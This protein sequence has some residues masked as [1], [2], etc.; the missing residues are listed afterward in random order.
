MQ[1]HNRRAIALLGICLLALGLFALS[2]EAV[3]ALARTGST[4]TQVRR[5][6]QR[7]IALGYLSGSADGIFGEKTRSALVQ[8]QRDKGIS[9]DGVAGVVTLTALG[10]VFQ[11]GDSGEDVTA[12]QQKLTALGYYSGSTDGIFGSATAAAVRSFQANNSLT[13]DGIVGFATAQ[14]L[15][16]GT[17]AAKSASQSY[18]DNDYELLARIINAEA[19]GEPYQGQVAVGAVVLNRVRHPS[20]PDTI[21]GVVYQ[22]GAFTAVTDGQIHAD[23]TD[24]AYR[25]AQDALAGWDPS[26]GAIY[27]YNPDKTSNR[28]IRSRTVI[29]TIG[30]HVFCE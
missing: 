10:I 23:I 14:A 16:S 30:A 3:P 4:G 21:A 26:G 12:I 22:S 5:V 20:F 7:L 27:Y 17:A 28:W 11:R 29:A 24:S 2:P 25:A 15:Y 1:H 19:R 18:R 8:F 6:Q 13:R 9:A